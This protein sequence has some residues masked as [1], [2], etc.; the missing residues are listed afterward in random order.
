MAN[1]PTCNK[2]V[3]P[4]RAPSARVIGGR[5][6][7]FCSAECATA[8]AEAGATAAKARIV[9]ATEKPEKKPAAKPTSMLDEL[10]ATRARS[11]KTTNPI[12][13]GDVVEEH[14]APKRARTEPPR[15]PPRGGSGTRA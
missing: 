11:V 1:C 7:A 8:G 3:D 10:E 4:L 5:V 13:A 6:V 2:E 14:V 15:P 9:E 12:D